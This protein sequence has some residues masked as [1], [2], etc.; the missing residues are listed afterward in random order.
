M[1]K[2]FENLDPCMFFLYLNTAHTRGHSLKLIKP[3]CHL[4]VRK[5]SF[6]NRVIDTWNSL[7][8]SIYGFKGRIDKFYTVEG[9][10]KLIKLPCLSNTILYIRN[11]IRIA[12]RHLNYTN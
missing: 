3:I 10:Y 6:A 12:L 8:E 11:C 5:Y 1:F 9:L 2:G 4:D 7:D